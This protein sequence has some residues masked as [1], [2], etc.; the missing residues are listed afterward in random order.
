MSTCDF[1]TG[2]VE[3]DAPTSIGSYSLSLVMFSSQ[4]ETEEWSISVLNR[5][6]CTFTAVTYPQID[7]YLYS[8]AILS[9][10]MPSN[11]H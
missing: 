10:A 1:T 8:D 3:I 6:P 4:E 7:H 2:I 9:T 11:V 5:C